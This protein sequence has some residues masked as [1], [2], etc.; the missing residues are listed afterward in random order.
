[1]K[2]LEL[3][4]HSL[5]E[6]EET[7]IKATQEFGID[8][9]N[10]PDVNRIKIRSY[11][12]SEHLLNHNIAT[13][14]H[15]KSIADTLT[16]T[17]NQVEKLVHL[18]LKKVLIVSGDPPQSINIKPYDPPPIQVIEALKKKI[19]IVRYLWSLRPLQT[20]ISKRTTIL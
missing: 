5:K 20:I 12:G 7:A 3:V 17:V 19:P 11:E 18:G 10:I 14:P 2:L 13:V 16:N 8:G 15:I 9:I 4:P 1:M 6:L